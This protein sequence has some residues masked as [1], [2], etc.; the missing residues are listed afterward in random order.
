MLIQEGRMSS[1]AARQRISDYPVDNYA[2]K[3]IQEKHACNIVS[4]T[5]DDVNIPD[6][7]DS[8]NN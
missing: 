7:A 1:K 3:M 6:G 4:C 5:V 2:S 8:T